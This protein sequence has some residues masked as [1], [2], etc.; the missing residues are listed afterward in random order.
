M[1]LFSSS[2]RSVF[3]IAPLLAAAVLMSAAI[4]ARAEN[5][6]YTIVDYP[7]NQADTINAGTDS[8]I[9]TIITDGTLGTLNASNIVGGSPVRGPDAP[10]RSRGGT[11]GVA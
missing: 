2:R 6:T 7:D 3:V 1:S 11:G 10:S 4:N 8:V 9:G 5:I